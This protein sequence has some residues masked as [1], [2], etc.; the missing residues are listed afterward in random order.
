MIAF[1][2]DSTTSL[3]VPRSATLDGESLPLEPGQTPL[4]GD[5]VLDVSD[6]RPTVR[7]PDGTELSPPAHVG[8]PIVIGLADGRRG[9]M[10]GLLGNA[11][12]DPTDDLV[13]R[14]GTPVTDVHDL[15]QLYG[16][17]GSSWRIQPAD[18]LFDTTLADGLLTP[19]DPTGAATL[20]DLDK[21][22]RDDAERVCRER[23][24]Q[25]GSGLEACVLDVAVSGDDSLAE[26]AAQ[27]APAL[28]QS[29]DVGALGPPEGG[30]RTLR[31][32]VPVSGSLDTAL[33]P[34][35]YV[36]ALQAGSTAVVSTESC[37]PDGTFSITLVAPD[38]RP[39]DRTRGDG[40]GSLTVPDLPASGLYAVRVSDS[41]GFTGDYRFKL[42]GDPIVLRANEH[43]ALQGALPAPGL[44]DAY[45][46]RGRAGQRV[47]VDTQ[48]A[49]GGLAAELRAAGSTVVIARWELSDATA[50][51]FDGGPVVLP[52][53]G[54]Y[55][56][57]VSGKD[58]AATGSYGL[59][60]WDVRD[61]PRTTLSYLDFSSI[62]GLNLGG[63][64]KQKDDNVVRLTDYFW[65][66]GAVWSTTPID[67][68]GDFHTTFALSMHGGSIPS[69]AD[70]MVLVLQPGSPTGVGG[71]GGALGYIGIRPSVAVEFDIYPNGSDQ[72][73]NQVEITSTNAAGAWVSRATA[74]PGF[75][76]H[77]GGPVYAWVDYEAGTRALAVYVSD[78]TTKPDQPTVSATVPIGGLLGSTAYAG[79]TGSTGGA[80]VLTDLL[81]WQLDNELLPG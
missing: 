62:S 22:V 58:S 52:E 8:S 70:G 43:I 49:L 6:G 29:V 81:R 1:G 23:G 32:G 31:V 45:D 3:S 78:T 61:R 65:Q 76:L 80:Y 33:T 66:A 72:G 68:R 64:A 24:L 48:L 77:N 74:D 41:G 13:A 11:N 5:A 47:F 46:F 30:T 35:E 54:I 26:S 44:T 14:G 75:P 34:D 27:V 63:S 25:P 39:L 59:R 60:V 57:S 71:A 10:R 28:E 73:D 2:D 9:D 19:V 16:S 51:T 4:P 12:A 79:F 38:G 37:P 53:D 50:A 7:W 17:F 21:S 20:S 69:R 40:C 15:A 67:P 18:S 42:D 36:V 55:T 56:L